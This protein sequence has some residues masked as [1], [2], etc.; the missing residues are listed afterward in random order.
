MQID[1]LVQDIERRY[2][3]MVSTEE[4]I[5]W[6]EI[7]CKEG[8]EAADYD[9]IELQAVAAYADPFN[10]EETICEPIG[11]GDSW[12]DEIVAVMWTVYGHRKTGGVE[13]WID[14]STRPIAERVVKILENAINY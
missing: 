10:H 14:C 3:G 4:Q 9:N 5:C 13:A 11:N 12:S 8:I 7:Q 1:L 2:D 6:L